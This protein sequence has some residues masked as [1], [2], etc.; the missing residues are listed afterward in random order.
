MIRRKVA[1]IFHISCLFHFR[2]VCW[3]RHMMIL[4]LIFLNKSIL[5]FKKIHL[6]RHH[7]FTWLFSC[8]IYKIK[9]NSTKLNRSSLAFNSESNA[10][11]AQVTTVMMPSKLILRLKASKLSN[12]LI[13]AKQEL[14]ML[15]FNTTRITNSFKKLII[16]LSPNFWK[17]VLFRKMN[18]LK[19]IGMNLH[20]CGRKPS[21]WL[22]WELI[23]SHLMQVSCWINMV[24]VNWVKYRL[25]K[26]I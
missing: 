13:L 8:L 21:T 18:S 10:Y 19:L 15:T 26:F 23:K 14:F 17:R 4:K 2:I 5:V 16:C 9:K 12:I 24:K 7:S 11:S 20:K 22:L 6:Q 25:R 3:A 1:M